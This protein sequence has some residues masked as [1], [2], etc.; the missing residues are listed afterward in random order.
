MT[1]LL[2][3][4]SRRNSITSDCELELK[5]RSLIRLW[6]IPISRD[7]FP[8]NCKKFFTWNSCNRSESFSWWESCFDKIKDHP[9]QIIK[10]TRVKRSNE[11]TR[12]ENLCYVFCQFKRTLIHNTLHIPRPF[13]QNSA[14]ALG[15][16]TT[17]RFIPLDAMFS[18]TT[19]EGTPTH[20]GSL[21]SDWACSVCINL[22]FHETFI[23][24]EKN[25]PLPSIAFKWLGNRLICMAR[26]NTPRLDVEAYL[27][28]VS[29]FNRIVIDYF[30][31]EDIPNVFPPDVVSSHRSL[32]M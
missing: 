23:P 3:S 16:A 1:F 4:C 26:W 29:S 7:V 6:L 14:S 12:S 8:E 22:R 25:K 27:P 21:I 32:S 31:L 30:R 11:R 28:V 17:D 5:G 13:A 24:L 2:S 19:Y 18:L 9:W 20:G 15:C 10:I